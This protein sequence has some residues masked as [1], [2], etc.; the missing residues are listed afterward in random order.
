MYEKFLTLFIL[1]FVSSCGGGGGSSAPGSSA[2]LVS[3]VAAD[4]SPPTFS[5]FTSSVPFVSIGSSS[6]NITLS[7]TLQDSPSGIK[8]DELPTPKLKKTGAVDI[9]ANSA[10]ELI[11][12]DN[13]N[14]TYS[15]TVTVPTTTPPGGYYLSSMFWYD[16]WGNVGI[17]TTPVAGGAGNNGLTVI[18]N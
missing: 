6:E 11:S 7:I 2:S 8:I 1:L 15:A 12:G 14:G 18:N 13:K 16:I 10:W 5:D 9:E 17:S 3:S 4:S